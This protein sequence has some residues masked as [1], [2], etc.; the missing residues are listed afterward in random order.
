LTVCGDHRSEA[1]QQA[2]I[3]PFNVNKL[4]RIT[5]SQDFLATER[6]LGTQARALHKDGG[7][8]MKAFR[9]LVQAAGADGA[10]SHKQKELIALAIA[11]AIRCDGCIIFHTRSCIKLGVTRPEVVEMIGVAVE[12]GGG[13]ASVY[14]AE[15]LSCFDQMAAGAA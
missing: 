3:Y 9:D 14:G 15:A 12:M 6:E 7:A 13:P 11:I 4:R 8:P 10:L 5:M 2:S 1:E